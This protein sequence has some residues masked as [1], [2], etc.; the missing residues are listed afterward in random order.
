VVPGPLFADDRSETVPDRSPLPLAA[1][2][3]STMKEKV[4]ARIDDVVNKQFIREDGG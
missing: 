1:R 3:M 4:F 2:L